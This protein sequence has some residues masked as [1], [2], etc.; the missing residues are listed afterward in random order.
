MYTYISRTTGIIWKKNF[1]H[2]RNWRIKNWLETDQFYCRP[3]W[4]VT[5]WLETNQFSIQAIHRFDLV[6]PI[7]IS[8]WRRWHKTG[9]TARTAQ[10]ISILRVPA[11][12]AQFIALYTPKIA[13]PLATVTRQKNK[14]SN[15]PISSLALRRI[16][17][18]RATRNSIYRWT[19]DMRK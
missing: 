11:Y 2:K 3:N 12:N 15:R 4:P 13:A 9:R 7:L 14:Q 19:S 8:V 1:P 5:Y 17:S 6:N 18:D 10:I 16:V